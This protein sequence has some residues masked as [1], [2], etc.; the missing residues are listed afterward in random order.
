[1]RPVMANAPR[2]CLVVGA[3]DIG[4]RHLDAL[5]TSALVDK[6]IVC[7]SDASISDSLPPG[8]EFSTV[9]DNALEDPGLIAAFICTPEGAHRAAV[10]TVL[11]HHVPVFCEKP[12]ASSIQD[13]DAMIA[14]AHESG[15]KLVVGHLLR[16]DPRLLRLKAAVDEG[17]LGR[18]LRVHQRRTCPL[19]DG[20]RVAERTTL[21]LYLGVHDLDVA[22]WFA[23][24]IVSVYGE[25]A[26]TGLIGVGEP[27]TIVAV[28]R[29][30]SGAVGVLELSWS[31]PD[32]DGVEF[33]SLLSVAGTSGAGYVDTAETGVAISTPERTERP[34]CSFWYS[35]HG[36]ALGILRSQD[37]Y[38]LNSLWSNAPWPVSLDDARAA[39]AAALA[40]DR[41]ID[42]NRPIRLDEAAELV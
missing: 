27:D 13:A 15:A 16:F 23:G 38:F 5:R 24:T 36:Q 30:S 10:E 26:S 20:R 41:S 12:I 19:S 6:C 39:L 37:E 25:A 3:G 7:D 33:D 9:L 1:M 32:S 2:S 42:S 29:F 22:A 34:D 8:V 14:L 21:P 35:T 18:I 40:I 31:V 17:V 11:R 28:L 4:R